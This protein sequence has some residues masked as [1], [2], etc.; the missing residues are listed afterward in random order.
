MIHVVY[1]LIIFTLIT[2]ER[3]R[4]AQ[5]S[6]YKLELNKLYDLIKALTD[7]INSIC[8]KQS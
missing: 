6:E 1:L 4:Q 3:M 5:I 8:D 2:C 7:K